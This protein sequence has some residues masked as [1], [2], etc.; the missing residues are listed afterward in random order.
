ML[1]IQVIMNRFPYFVSDFYNF[2][3]YFEISP[4]YFLKLHPCA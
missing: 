2:L 4:G 3:Y 1:R